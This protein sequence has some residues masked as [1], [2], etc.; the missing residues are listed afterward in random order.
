MNY[1]HIAPVVK[2]VQISDSHLFAE[3]NGQHVGVNVYQNLIE[4]MHAISE[5]NDLDAIIFTGDL[6]QDHTEQSY[7]RFTDA[8]AASSISCPVYFLAGNHDDP[9]VLNDVLSAA[10]CKNEKLFSI[11]NWQIALLNSKSATPAGYFNVKEH[12]PLLGKLAPAANKLF[13]MHHHPVDV[14]Y[15]IDRHHLTNNEEFWKTINAV[16]NLR[17]VACGH[18]HQGATISIGQGHNLVPLYTCPATSIQ[19]DPKASTMKALDK[20]PGYRIFSL[21]DD[22]KIGTEVIYLP[23][24]NST[25]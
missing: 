18:V 19:F 20:G 21:Y 1:K 2:L 6:T 22:G 16:S 11:N 23:A 5:I 3:T 8:L 10:G 9:E 15:F 25:T 7:Y 12:Q 14:G 24:K 4:V 13:F 17:A